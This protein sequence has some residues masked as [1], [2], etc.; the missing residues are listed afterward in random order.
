VDPADPDVNVAAP[1]VMLPRPVI[2]P[3]VSD[4][5]FRSNVAVTVTADESGSD[6]DP[7]SFREPAEIVVAPVNVLMP[8]NVSVPEPCFVK[9]PLVP[10]ITPANVV[11]ASPAEINVPEPRAMLTLV[12][13]PDV[14]ID[15][16]VSL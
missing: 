10:L 1:S 6:P 11:V 12:P 9:L 15:P 5:P 16:T 13:A 3:T 4:T 8:E 14:A 2:E 7:L